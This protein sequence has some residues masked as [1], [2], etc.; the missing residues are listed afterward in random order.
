MK[1]IIPTLA[2]ALLA[3]T[4]APALAET[5]VETKPARSARGTRRRP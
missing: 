1:K 2:A 4:I 5:T 3:A